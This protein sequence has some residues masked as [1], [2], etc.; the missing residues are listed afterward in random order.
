MTEYK[1]SDNPYSPGTA[2]ALT[3]ISDLKPQDP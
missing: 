2:H 3:Q 1:L